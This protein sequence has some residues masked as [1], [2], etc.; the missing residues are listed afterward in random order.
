MAFAFYLTQK[1]MI[2]LSLGWI[3]E[4]G[5]KPDS[6]LYPAGIFIISLTASMILYLAIEKRAEIY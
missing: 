6:L 1:Q 5:V 2:H 4:L 3:T